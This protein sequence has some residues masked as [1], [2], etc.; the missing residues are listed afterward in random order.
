MIHLTLIS[1]PDRAA[2]RQALAALGLRAS[3]ITTALR[4]QP[5]FLGDFD[6]TVNLEPLLEAGCEFETTEAEP[7]GEPEELS[8]LEELAMAGQIAAILLGA[9]S[10]DPQ[11]AA[12][13]A[14][15]LA[16]NLGEGET[17]GGPFTAALQL[18]LSTFNDA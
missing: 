7:E 3:E 13:A 2:A 1:Y 12:N 4:T 8:E 14:L 6:E 16:R 18:L 5:I 17:G 15:W 9:S 10:G 11:R